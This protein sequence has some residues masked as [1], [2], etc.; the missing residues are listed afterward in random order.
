MLEDLES[1]FDFAYLL[2]RNSP[3]FLAPAE[4]ISLFLQARSY[5]AVATRPPDLE[6]LAGTRRTAQAT[7]LR[8]SVRIASH[9]KS[10]VSG[11]LLYPSLLFCRTETRTF[12][13]GHGRLVLLL[14]R[15][16]RNR[17]AHMLYGNTAPRSWLGSAWPLVKAGKWLWCL[18]SCAGPFKP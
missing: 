3:R 14:S 15:K 12:L 4:D 6:T 18:G 10:A 11:Q 17:L 7:M 1:F 16:M 8:G 2:N 13:G 5:H 9:S